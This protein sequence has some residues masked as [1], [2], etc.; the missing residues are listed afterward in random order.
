MVKWLQKD[1]KGGCRE[2][3]SIEDFPK[4]VVGFVYKITN[5]CDGRIYVGRKILYNKLSKPLTKKEISEWSKPGKVP[6]KK[7]VIKESDWESYWGSNKHIKEDL[8]TMGEHC[9]SREILKLCKNKKQLSYY[10][11]Y[12]Q[13]KLDVLA[14]DSYN[15]NIAGKFYRKDLE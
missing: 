9:F 6:K 7:K 2:Y 3:A 13:M 5:L 1:E 12:W 10:E 8:Q 11:V 4:E 15:D 14:I